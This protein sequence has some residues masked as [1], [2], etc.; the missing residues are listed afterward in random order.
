M[1]HAA[2]SLLAVNRHAVLLAAEGLNP[3]MH[4][5][6]PDGGAAG[7]AD[8]HNGA[9]L[10][11]LLDLLQLLR[12]NARSVVRDQDMKRLLIRIAIDQNG[13][14]ALLFVKAMNHDI[15]HKR[16][17]NTDGNGDRGTAPPL[18]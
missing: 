1:H 10:Q 2:L 9:G 4:I 11:R 18:G 14:A 8:F 12:R 13:T 17:Q 7:G 5:Q 6:K 3:L 15:F 16:L